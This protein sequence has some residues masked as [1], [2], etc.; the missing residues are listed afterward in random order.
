MA[1]ADW[2]SGFDYLPASSLTIGVTPLFTASAFFDP[3]TT[4]FR[5]GT[6]S[7][8]TTSG[9]NGFAYR[10]GLTA[11]ATYS[12]GFWFYTT[13]LT[14]AGNIVALGEGVLNAAASHISIRL[15]TT[16][17]LQVLRGGGLGSGQASVTQIGS[18]SVNTIAIN[19]GYHIVVTVTVSDSVGVVTVTV[20][21]SSTGWHALTG[22]D[23]QNGGAAQISAFGIGGTHNGGSVFFDDVW[24]AA[25]NLGDCRVTPINASTGDGALADFTP[26]TG[27]DN[28]AMVDENPPDSD[29]TYNSSTT[30]GNRDTYDFPASGIVG[31]TLH[32][33]KLHNYARK[34]DAGT[35]S[36]RPVIRIGGVNYEGTEQFM[37]TTY[38]HVTQQYDISPATSVDW[39]VAEIDG[40]QF[41]IRHHA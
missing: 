8:L 15:T 4:Q 21:G 34:N 26:S 38:S 33:L 37:P 25:T 30:A 11:R 9:N 3:S 2:F 24:M 14:S 5:T 16:G 10:S 29:T 17:K 20:N 27:S 35:V 41:G 22:Q 7:L 18:D 12:L 1:V 28:G 36:I 39:T 19:T 13:S 32:G 6:R 31:S 23:T 40:A